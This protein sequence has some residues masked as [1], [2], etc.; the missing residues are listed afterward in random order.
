MKAILVF[1]F[2]TVG[3]CAMAQQVNY[4]I[5][6]DDP[7]NVKAFS[8]SLEPF[9]CD[10]YP[11]DLHMGY[12]V[13]AD[14]LFLKRMELRAD[15]RRAYLDING[16]ETNTTEYYPKNG[17]K[18]ATYG[19]AGFSLFLTDKLRSTEVKLV[20]SSRSYGDY[21]FTRYIMVPATKRK[22]WG[23]RGGMYNNRVAYEM[24][25][26][27]SF[28]V[29]KGT[30]D[31]ETPAVDN[32]VTMVNTSCLYG[33]LHWKSIVDLVAST[34]YGTRKVGKMAD[35][36]IDFLFAPVVAFGDVR[37]PGGVSEFSLKA[38]PDNIK[39]M[40]WRAGWAYR[41]PN[42]V[43]MCYKLEFGARPGFRSSDKPKFL[44][45]RSFM[46]FTFGINIPAIKKKKD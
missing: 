37:S 46:M 9:Y 1:V 12:S 21:T 19:E 15:F 30:N 8:L 42:K 6:S 2:L 4:R 27:D 29:M 39:R 28:F 31:T 32:T 35:F 24:N 20:L 10:L 36:Y 3:T 38:K 26:T 45:E 33:G 13:R 22:M 14:L 17:A 43:G 44:T 16:Q 25:G 7:E 5:L 41:H 11:L 18:F 34:D 40:G 23:V